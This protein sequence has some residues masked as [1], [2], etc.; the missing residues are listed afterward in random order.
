MA[1]ANTVIQLRK[2]GVSGNVPSSLNYG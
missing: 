2:S 1:T